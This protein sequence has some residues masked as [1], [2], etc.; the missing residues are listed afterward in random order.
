MHNEVYIRDAYSGK[1][2]ATFKMRV[3]LNDKCKKSFLSTG[4][5][6]RFCDVCRKLGASPGDDLHEIHLWAG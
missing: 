2:G 6:N 1:L 4:A 3:C 5:G